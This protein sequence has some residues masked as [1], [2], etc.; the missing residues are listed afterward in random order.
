MNTHPVDQYLRTLTR[1]QLFQRVGL[2]VGGFA[3]ANLLNNDLSAAPQNP[4][5]HFAP[6]AK[7]VIYFHLVGA[8]SHLDLFDYKPELQKRNGE[9]CPKE[10]FE[11]KQLAFIRSRPPCSVH[12]RIPNTNL[13]NVENPASGF[14]IYSLTCRPWQMICASSAL[15]IPS[16]LI[17]HWPRCLCRRG[18]SDSADP[19]LERGQIMGLDHPIRTFPDLWSWSPDHI[20]VPETVFSEVVF[21]PPYIRG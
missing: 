11:G 18:S 6:K 10:M 16:S 9:L 13:K 19:A 17:T 8:P 14:P 4:F 15:C 20:P 21:F 1:R 7:N 3:L 5:S 12:P 2:G